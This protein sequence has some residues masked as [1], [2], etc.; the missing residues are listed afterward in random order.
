MVAVFG[1]KEKKHCVFLAFQGCS[2]FMCVKLPS[3]SKWGRIALTDGVAVNGIHLLLHR[4]TVHY[5]NQKTM[6]EVKSGERQKHWQMRRMILSDIN[7]RLNHITEGLEYKHTYAVSSLAAAAI[8]TFL[9]PLFYLP[10]LFSLPIACL[11]PSL[12]FSSILSLV[13]LLL[14]LPPFNH[15]VLSRGFDTLRLLC[16]KD[17]SHLRSL[18]WALMQTTIP[19][20]W[21]CQTYRH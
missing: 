8:S 2:Q 21:C 18:C 9:S 1:K 17:D 11:G 6:K 15:T 19:P 13:A 12:L 3:V 20:Q 4:R 16:A 10:T 5:A 14:V 7:M